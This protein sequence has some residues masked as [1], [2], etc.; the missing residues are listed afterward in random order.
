MNY[1]E[2]KQAIEAGTMAVGDE[3]WIV[4][5]WYRD[6]NRSP[7]R[8]LPP[9]HVQIVRNNQDEPIR[10]IGYLEP[11]GYHFR[12]LGK[13][14]QPLAKIFSPHDYEWYTDELSAHIYLTEAEA[15]ADYREQIA[16]VMEQLDEA[17]DAVNVKFNLRRIG[18]QGRL[19]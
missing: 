12:P 7:A 3:V 5:Y 18:I 8:D 19:R 14:G 15:Q 10:Y 2:M 11:D 6:I 4:H 1:G 16:V 17:H 9:T 13:N